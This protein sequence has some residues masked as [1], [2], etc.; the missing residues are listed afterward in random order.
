MTC[1]G[2]RLVRPA[3]AESVRFNDTIRRNLKALGYDD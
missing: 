3:P 2:R 1:D